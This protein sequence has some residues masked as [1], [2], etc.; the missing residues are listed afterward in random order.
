MKRQKE[1]A[2]ASGGESALSMTCDA[3]GPSLR[4]QEVAYVLQG[5]LHVSFMYT[6]W[7]YH[8]SGTWPIGGPF[9]STSWPFS[10]SMILQEGVCIFTCNIYRHFYTGA[11]LRSN[12]L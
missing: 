10:T 3:D 2:A 8:G 9:S 6:P 7:K 12:T 5:V 1:K 11:T 4:Y